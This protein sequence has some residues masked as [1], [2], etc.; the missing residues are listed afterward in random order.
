MHALQSIETHYVGPTNTRGARIIAASASGI[1]SSIPYP[2]ELSGVE[3]HLQAALKLCA[4]LSWTG[5]LVGAGTK[6]GYVFSF[7]NGG[8]FA[9]T[10]EVLAAL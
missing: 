8:E 2:H 7:L 1:R 10:K 9:V 5:T 4:K 6:R 3:G